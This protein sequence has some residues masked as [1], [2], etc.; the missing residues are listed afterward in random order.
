MSRGYVRDLIT[1]TIKEWLE[2]D[3]VTYSAALAY[4][5]VLSLPA[6][7]LLSV[8]IGSIFIMSKSLQETILN[9]LDGII[10]EAM[11]NMII[12]LFEQIP[13][14]SSLS[15]SA[16]ISLI[17]LLW[18]ASNVFRQ[19]KNFLEKAWDI[20]PTESNRIKNFTRNTAISFVIVIFFGGLLVLSILVEGLLYAA[21]NLFQQFLLFSPLI[22]DYTGSIASFLILV[23]F[24][25]F[26]Y[27][28]L[29]DKSFDM[30]SIFV[31]SIVTAV[32]VTIGKYA[33]VFFIAYSNP[34]SIYGAIGSIIGLFLLFYYSSI[35]ITL[36]AE[37]TKIYS[38]S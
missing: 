29:P 38:E 6:L 34:T 10:D 31:G 11:K 7:L 35:M 17:L 16:L 21:S 24:F 36:G 13:D 22:I 20:K 12:L 2:D 15:I 37:F 14:L 5:F 9:H 1:E 32:L 8:S 3:A 25:I 23:L 26:V 19:L 28:V 18:S 33:I 30:K 4:Y 27:R